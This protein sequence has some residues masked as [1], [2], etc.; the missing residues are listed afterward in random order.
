MILNFVTLEDNRECV[1]LDE[2]SFNNEKYAILVNAL[3]KDDYIIRKI[4]GE[5]LIGLENEE[6][7]QQVLFA[8]LNSIG[9]GLNE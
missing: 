3:N 7:L 2:I 6:E 5:E 8:Y 9:G 1:L 4:V